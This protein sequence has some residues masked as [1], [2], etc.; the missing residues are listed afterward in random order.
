MSV[1]TVAGGIL[2]AVA[3]VVALLIV[4]AV[5]VEFLSEAPTAFEEICEVVH[6]DLVWIGK[7]LRLRKR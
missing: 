2:I 1:W 3:V 6:D 7:F 4:G 5:M